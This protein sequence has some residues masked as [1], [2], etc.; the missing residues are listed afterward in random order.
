MGQLVAWV[1]Q[2][3]VHLLAV[4]VVLMEVRVVPVLG[5]DLGHLVVEVR[6]ADEHALAAI[7]AGTSSNRHQH[8]HQRHIS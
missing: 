5:S 7:L 4:L 1:M 2:S 8:H 3:V 6:C